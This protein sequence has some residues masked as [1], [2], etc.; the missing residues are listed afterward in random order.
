MG[1]VAPGKKTHLLRYLQNFIS[2]DQSLILATTSCSVNLLFILMKRYYTS[3]I[4][5]L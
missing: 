4:R 1:V 5:S 2:E 3:I